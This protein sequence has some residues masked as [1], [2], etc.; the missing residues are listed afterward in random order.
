MSFFKLITWYFPEKKIF[1][2]VKWA[3]HHGIPNF[4]LSY[5]VKKVYKKLSGNQCHRYNKIEGFQTGKLSWSSQ[6]CSHAQRK[7]VL[8]WVGWLDP[9]GSKRHQQ[10]YRDSRSIA[11]WGL[12]YLVNC[13]RW[14]CNYLS[15]F[16]TQLGLELKYTIGHICKSVCWK[17][18]LTGEDS[19]CA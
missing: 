2:G 19:P 14:G 1:L 3:L 15:S 12:E 8:V 5:S 16:P 18:D 7:T 4:C 13:R 11:P 10:T 9:H 6:M 17:A